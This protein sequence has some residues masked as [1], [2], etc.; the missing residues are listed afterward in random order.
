MIKVGCCGWCESHQKYFKDFNVIEIQETFYEPGEISKYEKW[1]K[2]RPRG[3]EFVVKSWQLITHEPSSPT[4]R[5]LKVKIPESKKQNY[6]FFK[7]TKEVLEAWKKI[8]E[9]CQVL[10]TKIILFQSPTSFKPTLENKNNLK[11]FFKKVNRQNYIFV[12]EPRGEWKEREIK[13]I[14]KELN[15]V[16]CVD[17]LKEKSTYGEIN[18][19]RLHGLPGYN[20]YYR[21][22]EKDLKKLKKTCDRKINYVM[23]NNLSMLQD[24]KRFQKLI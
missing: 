4:Y 1:K 15:L 20:L 23:F 16:H 10:E 19:F 17:P 14:C 21:Y 12:W 6:G 24:A 18:Y 3:F 5:R 13:E 8:D 2:D 7:S 22:K 9:I 11:E